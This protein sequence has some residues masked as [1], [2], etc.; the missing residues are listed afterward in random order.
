MTTEQ[1]KKRRTVPAVRHEAARVRNPRRT[2]TV[3]EQ[4]LAKLGPDKFSAFEGR[5]AARTRPE[6]KRGSRKGRS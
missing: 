5:L 3:G 4:M 2:F 1:T 6:R